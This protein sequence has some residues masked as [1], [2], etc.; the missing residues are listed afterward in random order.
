MENHLIKNIIDFQ[1]TNYHF[2]IVAN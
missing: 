1:L 2:T